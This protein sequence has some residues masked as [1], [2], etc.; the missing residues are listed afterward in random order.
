MQGAESR[1][2][3]WR[4]RFMQGKVTS[5]TLVLRNKLGQLPR[6]WRENRVA[7]LSVPFQDTCSYP[8][9]PEP[10]PSPGAPQPQKNACHTLTLLPA[11]LAACPADP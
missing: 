2:S 5:Q 9:P 7:D 6:P 4:W 11:A 10:T 1:V 8:G 3:G